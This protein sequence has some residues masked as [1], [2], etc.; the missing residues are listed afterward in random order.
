MYKTADTVPCTFFTLPVLIPSSYN[1]VQVFCIHVGLFSLRFFV[2]VHDVNL[3]H[4]YLQTQTGLHNM[5][6]YLY[7]Q[8]EPW[9]VHEDL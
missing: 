4:M 9:V 1:K 7:M 3:E 2:F 5:Y 6:M 8:K